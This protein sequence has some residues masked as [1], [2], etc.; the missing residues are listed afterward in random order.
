[1]NNVFLKEGGVF[2]IDDGDI[3]TGLAIEGGIGEDYSVLL[4]ALLP[5]ERKKGVNCR[6]IPRLRM[7]MRESKG[8]DVV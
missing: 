1:L 8:T 2:C 4:E 7:T 5:P 3:E 6:V